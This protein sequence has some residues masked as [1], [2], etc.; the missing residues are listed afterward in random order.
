MECIAGAESGSIS[1]M[2]FEGRLSRNLLDAGK[3]KAEGSVYGHNRRYSTKIQE[4]AH[5]TIHSSATLSSNEQ[6]APSV[7]VGKMDCWVQLSHRKAHEIPSP[8]CHVLDLTAVLAVCQSGC[9][10]QQGRMQ[11]IS[12]PRCFKIARVRCFSDGTTSSFGLDQSSQDP[13]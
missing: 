6:F 2:D 5:L 4:V 8:A 10:M 1:L 7:P 9:S 13:N 12:K 11:S 3:G